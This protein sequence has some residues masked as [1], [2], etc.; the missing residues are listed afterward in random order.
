MKTA[1]HLF[2]TLLLLTLALA[3]RAEFKEDFESFQPTAAEA[4]NGWGAWSNFA[5]GQ[6][7]VVEAD[8]GHRLRLSGAGRLRVRIKEGLPADKDFLLA[9]NFRRPAD[10]SLYLQAGESGK[11]FTAV[12]AVEPKSG[13]CVFHVADENGQ[14]IMRST[15][16]ALPAETT[17]RLTIERRAGKLRL[18][19]ATTDGKVNLEGEEIVTHNSFGINYFN[20]M[21]V[22]GASGVAFELDNLLL[23]ALDGTTAAPAAPAA[24]AP[25]WPWPQGA[26]AAE[27]RANLKEMPRFWQDPAYAPAPERENFLGATN[28]G[29]ITKVTQEDY[30]KALKRWAQ[31][32]FVTLEELGRTFE[33]DPIYVV[34]VTSPEVPAARKQRVAIVTLHVGSEHSGFHAAMTALEYLVSPAARRYR[35][36]YEIA[37]VPTINPYGLF[38]AEGFCPWN[39]RHVIPYAPPESDWDINTLTFKKLADSPEL[40]AF[41]KLVD[42][43]QPEVLLDWHGV[44][45]S[46]PGEIMDEYVGGAGSN[47]ALAPWCDRAVEAMVQGAAR[48]GY[49]ASRVED[50]MQRLKS[51]T[52]ARDAFPRRFRES[53]ELLYPDMYPYLKYHT[54]PVIFEIAHEGMALGALKGLLDFGMT[55]PTE[56]KN[57]FPINN[58]RTDFGGFSVT[59]GGEDAVQQRASRAELWSQVEA[60]DTYRTAPRFKGRDLFVVT[61]GKRG[62]DAFFGGRDPDSTHNLYLTRLLADKANDANYDWDAINQFAL[63][64]PESHLAPLGGGMPRPENA[65]EEVTLRHGIG[66]AY[67]LPVASRYDVKLLDLRVNGKSLLAT[68]ERWRL[69]RGNNGYRLSITLPPEACAGV[70]YFVVSCAYKTNEPPYPWGWQPK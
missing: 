17:V 13:R 39:S 21:S 36:A 22:D 70:S 1:A 50:N 8:G 12:F 68:P 20:M 43:F 67:D 46:I 14:N 30:H 51:V 48:D 60:I 47:H 64:G 4:W 38:R 55:P 28:T 24:Q 35:D 31:N 27:V 58:L 65:A 41:F 29:R 59:S 62:R 42:D 63:L 23:K 34:K 53:R 45:R 32:D 56:Y 15:G 18:H 3:A 10:G 6:L 52:A 25:E 49:H 11:P 16:V 44:G 57:S 61:L 69:L 2:V 19:A 33:D 66:F 40:A 54:M 7:E 37:V 9:F 5:A 26:G